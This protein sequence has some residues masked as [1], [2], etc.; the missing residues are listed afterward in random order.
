MNIRKAEKTEYEAVKEF[1][2]T[3]IDDMQGMEYHPKWQKGI[4]PA[5][6]EL[7]KALEDSELY[8]GLEDGKIISAMRVNHAATEGYEKIS[9]GTDAAE[10]EVTLIHMLGVAVSVQGKGIAKEMVQYV[11]D[12]AKEA[13]QKAVR[14]DVLFGNLPAYRLY[15][16]MGFKRMGDITL[17]YEDTGITDF[18]LYEYIL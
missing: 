18:T 4:Y 11:L 16:S 14:L 5:Y 2:N 8:I 13:G 10:D 9:W 7:E 17:F 3:L 1:Y 12:T 15:D 6:D